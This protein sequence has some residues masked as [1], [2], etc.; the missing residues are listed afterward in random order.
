MPKTQA[1]QRRARRVPVTMPVKVRVPNGGEAA[2]RDGQTRDLSTNG[3]FFFTDAVVAP[4]SLIELVLML[5]EEITLGPKYWV[6]CKARVVRVEEAA[7]D[8]SNGI[9]AV[10]EHCAVLPEA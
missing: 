8:G 2:E 3:I 6:C 9:A 10:M 7:Q 5:P 1:E 4:G